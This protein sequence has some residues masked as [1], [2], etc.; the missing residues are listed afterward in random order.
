M[1]EETAERRGERGEA[2]KEWA[3]GRGWKEGLEEAVNRS[4]QKGGFERGKI[5]ERDT[6][7]R[8][9]RKK[10]PRPPLLSRPRKK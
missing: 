6:R 9:P 2:V 7:Y 5:F 8:A 1:V 3:K 4:V 10:G